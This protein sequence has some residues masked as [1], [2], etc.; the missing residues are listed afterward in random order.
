VVLAINNGSASTQSRKVRLTVTVSDTGSGPG[1]MCFS[2]D[3][4]S[5]T[6]WEPF[7]GHKNWTLTSGSGGKAVYV[8]VQ[9][10]LGNE[11]RPASATINYAEPAKVDVRLFMA[12]GAVVI[13]IVAA[14][15][16]FAALRL[17]KRKRRG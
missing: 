8:K 1:T 4:I 6:Q 16:V 15:A 10:A 11:A 5:Y 17:R 3:G 12:I 7:A 9:D 14:V 13:V 2:D